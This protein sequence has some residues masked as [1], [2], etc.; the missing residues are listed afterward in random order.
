[1]SKACQRE[2]KVEREDS[3]QALSAKAHGKLLCH[4]K[5]ACFSMQLSEVTLSFNI[6]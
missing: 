1:M 4:F 3:W 2:K 5:M 6:C